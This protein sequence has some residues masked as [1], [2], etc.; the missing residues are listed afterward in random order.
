MSRFV[1]GSAVCVA[2][3]GVV[4]RFGRVVLVGLALVGVWK[5]AVCVGIVSPI[6]VHG[7]MSL[8]VVLG[9]L[10]KC[11]VLVGQAVVLGHVVG[12]PGVGV[13]LVVGSAVVLG[14]CCLPVRFS[15]G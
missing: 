1:I 12:V 7:E 6:G 5:C 8:D 9:V 4:R 10:W 14:N 15:A 13:F 3:F 11:W 2:S